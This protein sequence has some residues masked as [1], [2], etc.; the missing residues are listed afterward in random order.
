MVQTKRSK[1]GEGKGRLPAKVDPLGPTVLLAGEDQ[2]RYDRLA[3]QITAAV[4]P[5]DIIEAIFVRDFVDLVWETLRLR[6]LKVSYL[7]SC[8]WVG[9]EAVLQALVGDDQAEILARERHRGSAEAAATVDAVL[10]AAGLTFEAATAQTLA[11]CL[12]EVE[13]TERMIDRAESGKNVALRELDRHRAALAEQLRR[14]EDVQ[15]AEFSEVPAGENA[16]LKRHPS[17]E[18]ERLGWHPDNDARVKRHAG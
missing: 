2:A 1:P 16:R 8:E 4:S 18:E 13:R 12:D 17:D 14:A 5:R 10:A 9:V 15:D 11:N 6:R 3:A 7:R